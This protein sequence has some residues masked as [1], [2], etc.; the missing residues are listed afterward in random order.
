MIE[1]LIVWLII[2]L[3]IAALIGKFISWG[4]NDE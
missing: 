4:M 2:S 3:P 1:I